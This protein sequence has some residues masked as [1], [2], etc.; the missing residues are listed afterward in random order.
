MAA[1]TQKVITRKSEELGQR[2]M[3]LAENIV[4]LL[5]P[6]PLPH[7]LRVLKEAE[8][9]ITGG[10]KKI[11]TRKVSRS[12]GSL[13]VSVP[14]EV[15]GRYKLKIDKKAGILVYV[16]DPEGEISVRF[17]KGA[18][19]PVPKGAWE[20]IGKPEY[21]IIEVYKDKIILAPA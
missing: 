21:V 2:E 12:G 16:R 18:K 17:S 13:V 1:E 15:M 5:E 11:I 8:R 14:Q 6:L 20:E 9:L 4:K 3:S 10:Y 7:K 19:L